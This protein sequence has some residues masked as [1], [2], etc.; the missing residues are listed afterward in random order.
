[1]DLDKHFAGFI[2]NNGAVATIKGAIAGSRARG[3]PL[4][5]T[6]L[7]GPPGTGKTTLAK[8]IAD[9]MDAKFVLINCG[10]LE[11][12]D[13][14]NSLL[15]EGQVPLQAC[16]N[17]DFELVAGPTVVFWEE[18][19]AIPR[20]P[21]TEMLSPMLEKWHVNSEGITI[22]TSNIT[23]LL[24]TTNPEDLVKPLRD[25]CALQTHLSRYSVPELAEIC[26]AFTVQDRNLVDGAWKPQWYEI[27]YSRDV[28]L[29]IA[30]CARFNPRIAL[31]GIAK[32]FYTYLRGNTRSVEHALEHATLK[33]LCF[34]L[35]MQG[36]GPQGLKRQD[37]EYLRALAGS[38]KPMGLQS[39]A[40]LLDVTKPTLEQDVEPFL[41]SLKMVQIDRSGRRLTQ[42]GRDYLARID[43]KRARA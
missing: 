26:S 14:L 13:C 17:G 29:Q 1:M 27:R 3:V 20:K 28:L 19:H 42:I 43:R 18:A 12:R 23:F 21:Q 38:K 8:L 9:A 22:D 25:R 6:L 37:V 11:A 34:Y 30:D 35:H 31:E 7:T 16:Y 39:I 36:M 10:T 5:H 40:S 4:P 41:R 2:G 24:A 15:F 33:N 32:P